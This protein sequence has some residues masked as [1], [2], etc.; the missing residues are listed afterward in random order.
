M[1]IIF[2]FLVFVNA[3][4]PTA[5]RKSAPPGLNYTIYSCVVR[6]TKDPPARS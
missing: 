3:R 5:F 4:A 2:P 6:S 1:G